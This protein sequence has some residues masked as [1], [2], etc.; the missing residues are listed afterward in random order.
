MNE[1]NYIL[2]QNMS[3]YAPTQS[4]GASEIDPDLKHY[5]LPIRENENR[6]LRVIVNNVVNPNR[7]VTFYFDRTMRGKL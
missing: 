5:L 1:V 4:M 6:V 2:K 7:I 3:E